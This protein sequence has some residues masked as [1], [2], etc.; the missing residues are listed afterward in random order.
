MSINSSENEN[1]NKYPEVSLAYSSLDN[2]IRNSQSIVVEQALEFIPDVT[3]KLIESLEKLSGGK[4]YL[5]L[6][7]TRSY[8]MD[9][10]A[11]IGD[12]QI[13]LGGDV[14]SK[15]RVLSWNNAKD[16]GI[17]IAKF[18]PILYETMHPEG[19]EFEGFDQIRKY[20]HSTQ[21]GINLPEPSIEFTFGRDWNHF[22]PIFSEFNDLVDEIKAKFPNAK[23]DRY[24]ETSAMAEEKMREA[25]ASTAPELKNRIKQLVD[26]IVSVRFFPTFLPKYIEGGDNTSRY[27]NGTDFFF[28]PQ[29]MKIVQAP[30]VAGLDGNML[31]AK[32]KFRKSI[33]I[34]D[35]SFWFKMAPSIKTWLIEP[36]REKGWRP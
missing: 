15:Y 35:Q 13:Q 31:R 6:G 34:D 2:A 20:P 21:I 3:T 1:Q 17:E 25:M 22:E 11:E 9:I 4:K 8:K 24:H 10:K 5:D 29:E 30:V 12:H 16:N 19:N 26:S 23:F 14:T 36:L 28:L 7:R 32:P 27:K 18:D 33:D